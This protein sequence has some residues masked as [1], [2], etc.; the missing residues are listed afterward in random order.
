MAKVRFDWDPR[1]DRINQEKHGVSFAKAQLAFADR[2]RVIAA[3]LSHGARERRYF[4]F[5]RAG[6]G[7][8]TVR[9]TLGAE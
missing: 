4:C 8:L 2:R 3:D 5:G 1:K 9:F 6:E 7:I